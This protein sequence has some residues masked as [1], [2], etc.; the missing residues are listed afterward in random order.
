MAWW[1]VP[2]IPDTWEAQQGDDR[3]DI[4]NLQSENVQGDSFT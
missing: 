3:G 4:V 1:C 2:I